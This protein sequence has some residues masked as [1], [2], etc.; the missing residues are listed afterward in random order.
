VHFWETGWKMNLF[1]SMNLLQ[2]LIL[3]HF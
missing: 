2:I 3:N 1:Q